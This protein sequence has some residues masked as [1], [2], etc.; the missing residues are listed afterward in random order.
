MATR[1]S[2]TISF[3]VHPLFFAI[4][5]LYFIFGKGVTFIIC[6]LSAVI[7]ELAHSLY[8]RKIGYKLNRIVLMPYGAAVKG[9]IDGLRVKEEVILCLCG[10]L[11]NGVIAL[12]FL[13]SW[14]FFPESYPYTEEV[15]TVNFALFIFNLCPFY[16]LDGGRIAYR[17]LSE[18][19]KKAATYGCAA[20][21][22][23]S[24]VFLAVA[25]FVTLK[26]GVNISLIAASAFLFCSAF[27]KKMGDYGK[28]RSFVKPNLKRGVE[29]T[30]FAVEESFEIKDIFH[31]LRAD[32]YLILDVFSI[33]GEFK[34]SI[35]Q[36]EIVKILENAQI[37]AKIGD[38]M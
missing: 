36:D 19:S 30:R 1:S 5:A 9:D 23:L 16:P 18:R 26:N 7:H 2:G 31:L 27:M 35:R 22:V 33:E 29:I 17:L 6:A 14:W 25:F 37:Y 24:A 10:P 15:V 12:F 11:S 4:G 20:I 21:S 32:K 8:A 38:F 13:S 28:I 34:G 3:S